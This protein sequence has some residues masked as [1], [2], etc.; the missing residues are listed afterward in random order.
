MFEAVFKHVKIIFSAFVV[1]SV[2][3]VAASIY[4]ARILGPEVFAVFIASQLFREIVRIPFAASFNLPLYDFRKRVVYVSTRVSALILIS[5]LFYL[6]LLLVLLELGGNIVANIDKHVVL[7]LSFVFVLSALGSVVTSIMHSRNQYKMVAKINIASTIASTFISLV[8]IIFFQTIYVLVVKEIIYRLLLLIGNLNKAGGIAIIS[9]NF[10]IKK[11]V[12]RVLLFQSYKIWAIN[13]LDFVT[14]RLDKYLVNLFYTPVALSNLHQARYYAELPSTLI[15]PMTPLLYE[16]FSDPTYSQ[17]SKKNL[18]RQIS[19]L[20]VALGLC[21]GVSLYTLGPATI[22]FLLGD[23]WALAAEF[24]Q[25]LSFYVALLP[26][27]NFIKIVAYHRKQN[28]SVVCA[29]IIQ[30]CTFIISFYWVNQNYTLQMLPGVFF[31]STLFYI[32]SLLFIM[33]V[34]KSHA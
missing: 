24:S 25:G 14:T 3:N 10:K 32:F 17:E 7:A 9:P 23:D 11:T 27:A 15:M 1:T 2:I 28:R 20:L 34:S 18:V 26:Y 19:I 16:K 6:T 22:L 33:R 13:F 21:F 8:L 31:I 5:F 30:I 29:Q 4:F 12:I